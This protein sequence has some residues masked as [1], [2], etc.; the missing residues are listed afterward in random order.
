MQPIVRIASPF[1]SGVAP[2]FAS[3]LKDATAKKIKSGF[4]S[5][6]A[7]GNDKAGFSL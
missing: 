7:G 3:E 5:S 4:N 2:S 6:L 1:T